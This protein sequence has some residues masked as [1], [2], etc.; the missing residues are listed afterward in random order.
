MISLGLGDAAAGPIRVTAPLA[1]ARG[2]DASRED[3]D[4]PSTRSASFKDRR[5]R[6][7]RDCLRVDVTPSTV[8]L[9][10]QRLASAGFIWSLPAEM[11]DSALEAALFAAVGTKQGHR[12]HLAVG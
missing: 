10:L 8:R 5:G 1:F 11:T 2:A 3:A 7:Q 9:M 12:R 6:A 4:A